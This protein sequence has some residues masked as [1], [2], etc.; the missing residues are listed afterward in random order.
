MMCKDW[1]E[2][3]GGGI[4]VLCR[5]DWKMKEIDLSGNEY[6]CFW[7]KISAPNQ[8]YCVASVCHPLTFEYNESDFIEFLVNSCERMLAA[9]PNAR[10][11]I[12]RDVN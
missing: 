9:S 11:V 7:A 1:T 5:N 3:R 4:A 6:E 12:V 10:L 2:K 8:D